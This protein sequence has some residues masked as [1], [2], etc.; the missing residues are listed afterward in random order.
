MD[1]AIYVNK[2]IIDSEKGYYK[3]KGIFINQGYVES[4]IINKKI[5]FKIMFQDKNEWLICNNPWAKCLRE[6]T[7]RPL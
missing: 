7:W 3:V 5:K 4:F 6:Q 1:V 2:V